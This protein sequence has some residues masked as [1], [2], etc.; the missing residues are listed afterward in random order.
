MSCIAMSASVSG[1]PRAVDWGRF[2]PV[3]LG[4]V[5]AAVIAN[6]LVSVLGG[7]LVHD[8]PQVGA[9]VNV[10][11]TTVVA[12]VP[13]L[14]AVLLYA[15]LLRLTDDPARIFAMIAAAISFAIVAT[16][17]FAV[18]LIPDFTYASSQP[19]GMDGQT[20]LLVLLRVVTAGLIVWMLTTLSRP[21]AR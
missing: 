17:V 18:T 15:A 10:G 19:A 21:R 13:A 3:G 5:A 4:T 14:A 8:G 6:L 7:A 9:L 1:E 12:L 16:V 11:E 20:A 2:A